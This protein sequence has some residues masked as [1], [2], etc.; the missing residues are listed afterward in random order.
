MKR[1]RLALLAYGVCLALG[2]PQTSF[3][4]STWEPFDGVT[5]LVAWFTKLNEQFDQVVVAEKRGQLIRK[6]DRMR[7]DLYLLEADTRILQDS[8]PTQAPTAEQRAHLEQLASELMR[9]VEQLSGSAREV[10]ADLRLN[11]A[12]D[13]ERALTHGL[14]TRGIVLSNFQKALAEPAATWNAPD[15][16]KMLAQ[17]LKAVQEAQ[18]AVT[19]FRKK[20]G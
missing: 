1:C 4:Q 17:G 9:S 10:G 11:D 7:K 20:L 8:I 3:S 6:V 2:W 18:L 13:V 12:N 19:A 16:R 15:L 5:K 14:R